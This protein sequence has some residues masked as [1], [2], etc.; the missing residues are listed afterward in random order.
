MFK[1]EGIR[2]LTSRNSQEKENVDKIRDFHK[3]H[4][5]IWGVTWNQHALVTLQR[6]SLSRV[7]YYDQIYKNILGIPGCILEFGVQWGAT[8][9][10]LIALRG[11][12][13]PYNYRRHIYGFDTF[14]GFANTDS[15][16][17]GDHVEDGDYCVY[18][19][20]EVELEALLK[21]HEANWGLFR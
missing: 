2:E 17:D 13:E 9:S 3:Q 19:G 8:L 21:L 18:D 12:Y 15:Q 14:T 1:K 20:Y 10:Q 4:I 16:K 6:Q 7:L 5:D 11:M